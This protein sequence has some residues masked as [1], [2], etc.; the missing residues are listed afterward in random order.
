MLGQV[1]RFDMLKQL[2]KSNSKKMHKL[3]NFVQN[4]EIYYN[5]DDVS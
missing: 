5:P 2:N 4:I 3:P 1:T